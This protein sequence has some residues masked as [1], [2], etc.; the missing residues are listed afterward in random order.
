MKYGLFVVNKTRNIGDDIQAYATKRFLPR[1][2][3]YIDRDHADEFIP[4]SNEY[5]ASIINGWYLQYT[6]NWPLS[7][8][9]YPLPVSIHLTNK[10]F[11]HNT[12]S[13]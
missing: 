12:S 5:V 4:N 2:D 3:Y 8:F 11:F 9:I 7:P 6:L 1:V 13:R 10:D